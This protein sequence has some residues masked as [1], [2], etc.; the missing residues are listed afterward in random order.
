MHN[1]VNRGVSHFPKADNSMAIL[2]TQILSNKYDYVEEKKSESKKRC[3]K[4]TN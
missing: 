2:W 4:I 3:K 1:L